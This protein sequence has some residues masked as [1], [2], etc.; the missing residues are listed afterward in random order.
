MET[1]R[2]PKV[3]KLTEKNAKKGRELVKT[4]KLGIVLLAGGQGSRL[5][6]EGPKGTYFIEEL[7]KTIFGIQCLKV[8]KSKIHLFI[9]CSTENVEQTENFFETNDYFGMRGRI[10]FFVQNNFNLLDLDGTELKIEGKSVPASA[11]HGDVIRSLSK[12]MGLIDDLKISHLLISNIDNINAQLLDYNFIGESCESDLSLKVVEKLEPN[13]NVGVF[14]K[15]EEGRLA[16]LE[17]SEIPENLRNLRDNEGLYFRLAN[18][19]VQILSVSVIKKI[20]E[21]DIP[22]HYAYK[23]KRIKGKMY[24]FLKKEIFIF[25]FFKYIEDYKIFM[26]DKNSNF[27]PIKDK[28]SVS[29]AVQRYK[30]YHNI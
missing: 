17:Y 15:D 27:A 30:N 22:I 11:G 5:E 20:M 10:H 7:E 26:V 6:H 24:E 16:V 1:L 19:M 3:M 25:D 12:V 8:Q 23:K 21:K 9:M 2:R 13:E 14:C 4:G 18:I 29:E 28:A